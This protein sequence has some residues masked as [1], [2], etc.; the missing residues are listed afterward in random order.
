MSQMPKC[1]ECKKQG[2]TEFAPFCSKRCQ[3]IDLGRWLNGSYVVP[4]RTDES[5]RQHTDDV[6]K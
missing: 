6:D 3:Q 4:G 1:P 5:A 2:Q